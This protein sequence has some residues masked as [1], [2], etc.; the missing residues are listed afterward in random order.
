[1]TQQTT[2]RRRGLPV[3]EALELP[4]MFDVWPTVGEALGIGRTATYQL[5][6]ED[7]LPIPCIRVGRQLRARRSDLL[8]FLGIR[9]ENGD[10]AR[11][12]T[13]TPLAERTTESTGE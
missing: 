9:E 13:R 7:A 3:A 12:A 4:V 11:A 1:M 10:G 8:T 2:G 5:A 6:R